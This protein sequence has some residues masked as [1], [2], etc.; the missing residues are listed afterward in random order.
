MRWLPMNDFAN[1]AEV[2][3]VQD[4]DSRLHPEMLRLKRRGK[5]TGALGK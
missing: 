1:F 5:R 2:M 4:A 3:E